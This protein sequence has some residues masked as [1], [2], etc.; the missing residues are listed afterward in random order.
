ME[1]LEKA[2][3]RGRGGKE[4]EGREEKGRVPVETTTAVKKFEKKRCG[5]LPVHFD[6]D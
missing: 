1:P 5:S 2:G 4:G 3:K 6:R